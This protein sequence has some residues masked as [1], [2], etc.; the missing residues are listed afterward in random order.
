MVQT[1]IPLS[2]SELE[3]MIHRA[4]REELIRLLRTPSRPSSDEVRYRDQ[5]EEEAGDALLLREALTVLQEYGNT[6]E[7]WTAWEDLEAELESMEP[8]SGVSD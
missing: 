2:P 5:N 8:S 1:T 3:T 7:A 4:V 6:S